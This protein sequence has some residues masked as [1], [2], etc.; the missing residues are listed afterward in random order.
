MGKPLLK[1]AGGKSRLAVD[2]CEAFRE[3][4]SGT[5]FE[6]FVGSAAVFL[7]RRA[8]RR[9]GKAVL[10]DVN[11]K[12]VETHRAV[13]DDVDGVIR[14]LE[15]IGTANWRERYYDVREA[16]NTGPWDGPDHA[17]RFIWLNRACFN[18]L[19]RENRHGGFNVPI[20]SYTR[21]AIPEPA[22]F[23]EVSRLLQGVELVAGGFAAVLDRVRPGDQ[24]YC[25]PPYVPLT[26]TANF[27]GYSK[28]PFGPNEQMSLAQEAVRIGALGATV[29]LSNHDTPYVREHLYTDVAGFRVSRIDVSRAISRDGASRRPVGEVIAAIGGRRRVAA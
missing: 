14:A 12:L 28:E 8:R 18:G 22:Q 10:S 20:G 29:V 3:P 17:A 24:V 15:R 9:I 26:A 23:W 7:D 6:P 16:Y 13:R 4:C 5:Y 19:Y 11:S 2:I 1:W 27:T 21:L 25:D